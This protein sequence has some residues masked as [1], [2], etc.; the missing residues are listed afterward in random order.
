M[1]MANSPS[2]HFHWCTFWIHDHLIFAWGICD[3]SH[4]SPTILFLFVFV[5]FGYSLG[6][7]EVFPQPFGKVR[8]YLWLSAPPHWFEPC[9]VIILATTYNWAYR[10]YTSYLLIS[11]WLHLRDWMN[12][13]PDRSNRS[14]SIGVCRSCRCPERRWNYRFSSHHATI[15]TDPDRTYSWTLDTNQQ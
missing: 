11:N 10:H 14:E 5:G 4:K 2:W 12:F 1:R 7:F 15:P 9:S 6:N 3:I 13:H 8:Y